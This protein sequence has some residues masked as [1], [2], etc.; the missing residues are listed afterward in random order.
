MSDYLARIELHGAS[1]PNDYVSLHRK[2]A[3]K[4]FTNHISGS[5][6]VS[7][8]PPAMYFAPDRPEDLGEI[9]RWLV[10]IAES[11]KPN[12]DVI[13]VRDPDWSAYL[14]QVSR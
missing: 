8:L 5:A 10:Q 9:R 2:V 7:R 11:E 4:G 12:P 3:A 13:V 6:G 1:W 14:T